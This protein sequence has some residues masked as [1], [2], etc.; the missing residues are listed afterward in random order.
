MPKSF[1]AQT[2]I[3]NSIGRAY[4]GMVASAAPWHVGHG[5]NTSKQSATVTPVAANSAVYTLQITSGGTTV[6]YSYTADASATVAEITAGLTSA[7]NGGTQ[8]VTATD[9]TTA[10]GLAA[11]FYSPEYA[12]TAIGS[13][14][15]GGSLTVAAVTAQAAPLKDGFFVIFD[16]ATSSDPM[17]VKVPAQSS[18]VTS[19]NLSAG[20]SLADSISKV[21]LQNASVAPAMV[22]FMR[23]G[24][25]VVQCEEAV[26]ANSNVFVRYAAGGLGQGAF[27]ASA[28]SSERAQL[29]GAVYRSASFPL[30]D[31]SLGAVVEINIVGG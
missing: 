28:G 26:T 6:A 24:H 3:Q 15:G 8:P 11:D 21:R 1:V 13:T 17:A 7:V 22:S 4:A 19:V 12:F 9:N 25:V 31:G 10:V 16:S 27:G 29:N 5:L 18:D 20:V 30:A 2:S 23:K 14:S